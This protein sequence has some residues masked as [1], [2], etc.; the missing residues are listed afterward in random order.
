MRVLKERDAE[1]FGGLGVVGSGMSEDSVA[2]RD[3]GFGE[4]LTEVA[5]ANDGDF[6]AVIRGG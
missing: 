3:K 5:E 1:F 6:E 2:L 4:E